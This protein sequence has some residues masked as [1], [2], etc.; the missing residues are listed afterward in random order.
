MDLGKVPVASGGCC[1]LQTENH[2]C[3]ARFK[4]ES[5]WEGN[6]LVSLCLASRR[7]EYVVFNVQICH[8]RKK[9]VSP[10]A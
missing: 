4:G 7:T 10:P 5:C 9:Y 6:T 3:F 2:F 8:L 1:C